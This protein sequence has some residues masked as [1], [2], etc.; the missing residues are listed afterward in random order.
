[1]DEYKTYVKMVVDYAKVRET[2]D[3]ADV[4]SA[5]WPEISKARNKTYKQIW[6]QYKELTTKLAELKL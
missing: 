2:F 4:D 6:A 5:E 3:L 1:M